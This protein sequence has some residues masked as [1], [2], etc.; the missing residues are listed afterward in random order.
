MRDVCNTARGEVL[1]AIDGREMRLCV[2]L[3][4]L[5]ELEGAF[6]AGSLSELGERLAH[7]TANDLI[8]VLAALV[9]GG[10]DAMSARA[11]AAARIDPKAAAEAIAQAFSAAFDG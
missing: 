1:L 6:D 10:G 2:T 8:T 5:A 11:L 4:A 3:G 7:L 9:A